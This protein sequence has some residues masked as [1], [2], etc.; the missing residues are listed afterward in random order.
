MSGPVGAPDT[1]RAP[2]ATGG[3]RRPGRPGPP[4]R[5]GRAR[6]VGG[7]DRFVARAA[8]VTGL[9]LAAGALLGLLRDR[10]IAGL[11]GAGDA[12]DAFLVAWTIPEF[13]STLL[14]EDAM[15]L[16]LVPAF[17]LALARRA[18]HR[19]AG[20]TT[21]PDPV[22]ALVATGLPRLALW[23]AAAAAVPALAAPWVVRL[24]APGLADPAAAVA[25]TRLTSVTVLAF[26]VAGYFSALL[27]AHRSFAPPAAVYAAYNIGIV[28]CA[29][30]LHDLWG[31]RAAAVGVA[32]G[33]VLMVLVQ[34]PFVLRHLRAR[35][36]PDPDGPGARGAAGEPRG[37]RSPEAAGAM[38]FGVVLPVALF[39]LARQSQVLVERHL[40]SELPA[41]AISHLN[42]AQK[43]GQLPMVAA[44]MICTV[45]LPLV[46][47]ALADGDPDRARDRVERDLLLAGAIVLLG[48]AWMISCAPELVRLLFEQGAFDA[49]AGDAT[50]DVLRVY[51][52]GLLGHTLVGALIR[53]YCA[54]GRP[55]W[56][57]FAAMCA[58]LAVTVVAGTAFVER[59]GAPGI[60]AANALGVAVTALLMLCGGRFRVVPARPVPVLAGLARLALAALAA[61][62]AARPAADAVAGRLPA[63]P[64]DAALGAVTGG[65]VCGLVFAAVAVLLGAPALL[66]GPGAPWPR[67]RADRPPPGADGPGRGSSPPPAPD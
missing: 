47:R 16:V 59:W 64:A 21:G 27:R 10:T 50:A 28:V 57:P 8:G 5:P 66:G 34:L 51:A 40:A 55:G 56:Y 58:G 42:Y 60:A 11:Y 20:D 44:L 14:I 25:C 41:G 46:A 22:R 43:I 67:P 26:G 54:A 61:G 36:V 18:A 13:A 30:A 65:L 32:V 9:M 2:T 38:T 23:L 35:T 48:T 37:S 24:L 31:I 1:D 12:T 39:A 63:G 19:A 3:A 53:P 6:R 15:A 7:E 45:T 52:L 17:S 4:R 29:L 49:A 62:A 33:G